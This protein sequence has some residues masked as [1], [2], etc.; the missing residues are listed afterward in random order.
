MYNCSTLVVHCMDFC[1]VD[2]IQD[3]I[4]ESDVLSIS[5]GIK[6]LI[7]GSKEV[8]DFILKQINISYTLHNVRK[9]VLIHHNNCDAYKDSYNFPDKEAEFAQHLEDMNSAEEIIKNC[10]EDIEVKKI[11]VETDPHIQIIEL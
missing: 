10:F 11:W 1:L 6:D 2:K 8:Q 9:V 5:G 3:L 7:D 4:N